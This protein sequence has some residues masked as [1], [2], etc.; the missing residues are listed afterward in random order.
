M[1]DSCSEQVKVRGASR[2]GTLFF[3][4]NRLPGI[5]LV[6]QGFEHFDQ[7]VDVGVRRQVRQ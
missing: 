6:E 2:H 3:M 1:A 5:P 7:V 4:E